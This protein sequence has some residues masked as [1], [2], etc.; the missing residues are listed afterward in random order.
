MLAAAGLVFGLPVAAQEVERPSVAVIGQAARGAIP[1]RKKLT[2]LDAVL[3]ARP[4]PDADLES[5]AVLRTAGLAVHVL[6][7][8]VRSMLRRGDTA[9]NVVLQ[10][11]DLVVVPVTTGREDG[12]RIDRRVFEELAVVDDSGLAPGRRVRLLAWRLETDVDSARRQR[13]VAE[14]G[15]LGEQAAPAVPHLVRALGAEPRIAA[16]AATSLGLI[17]APARVALPKLKRLQ[18]SDDRQ[19]RARSRAAE[20]QIRAALRDR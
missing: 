3:L 14:L 17:G 11:G 16:E 4:R 9:T 19:L 2:V 13:I 7:V 8:D 10:P 12:M 18:G 5:V 15:L 6:E 20:R 1:W